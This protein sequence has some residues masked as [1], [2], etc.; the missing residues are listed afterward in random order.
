MR[1]PHDSAGMVAKP[2]VPHGV[3]SGRVPAAVG[4]ESGTDRASPPRTNAKPPVGRAKGT[5]VTNWPT[6]P[7]PFASRD[8]SEHAARNAH[9]ER[10]EGDR[11]C[12]GASFDIVLQFR[13]LSVYEL[14]GGE[15]PGKTD[16][17]MC[18]SAKFDHIFVC[19][20]GFFL[21]VGELNA[22][23]LRAN[24]PPLKPNSFTSAPRAFRNIPVASCT[25]FSASSAKKLVSA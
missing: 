21:C 8:N 19:D 11:N 24:V 5:R 25:P 6:V 9:P 20:I 1:V 23:G 3:M 22:W 7:L 15:V 13:K 10:D 16:G 17:G 2:Q 4:G 18:V 12:E 14:D